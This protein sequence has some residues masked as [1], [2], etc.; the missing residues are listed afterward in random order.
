MLK[1]WRH[2]GP[3]SHWCRARSAPYGVQI[4]GVEPTFEPRVS[5]VPGLVSEGRFLDDSSAPEIVIGTRLSRNLKVGIG[6]ELTVVGSGR[7]GS[8]AA[9]IVNV[10][11]V[12]D[13]G[14][15]E[16][17]RSFAEVPLQF[18][19]DT[20]AMGDAGHNIVV[21]A[22]D[23]SAV[24]GIQQAAQALLPATEGLT[25]YHWNRT[26]AGPSSRRSRRISREPGSC[27][28]CWSFSWRSV[29]STPN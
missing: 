16:V 28:A 3:L 20:F 4:V 15:S 19:Q 11:G 24:A 5:T 12:F 10:V 13:S 21:N 23:L 7:D 25:L 14:M 9:A 1:R 18:F 2:A 27:M 29:F 6:D 22:S 17:D 26:A 8:F